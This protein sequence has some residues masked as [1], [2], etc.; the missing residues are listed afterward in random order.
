[1]PVIRNISLRSH[2]NDLGGKIWNPAFRWTT[3]YSVF[4][5]LTDGKGRIGTGECWCFDS[6]PEALLAFIKT[7]VA[8]HFI[9]LDL[10]QA[11]DVCAKLTAKATLTARHGILAS[12]LSGIDIAIWDIRAQ[13]VGLPI[14]KCL[15]QQGSG[16]VDLYASG[17]LYGQEKDEAA[18]AA[19]MAGF[20]ADG[21]S[22]SKMKIGGESFEH[23]VKRVCAVIDALPAKAKLIVDGVYSYTSDQALKIYDALPQGRI[24]AFQ[25]P[26]RASDIAGM[27]R[28]SRA[29]VPVMATEAE[30]RDEMHRQLIDEAEIA[31]LQTAPIACGGISRVRAMSDLAKGTNTRLSLEV[32]STAIAM[33]A[34]CHIAAADE[35]IAHVEY[36]SIHTVFFEQLPFEF[37]VSTT[38]ANEMPATSG[39][40][41]TLDH[42]RTQSEC[43]IT[44][45]S[46]EKVPRQ[47]AE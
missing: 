38:G 12:A 37:P 41:I 15:N 13:S 44:T 17:G 18:L 9:D 21:F 40:G 33:M 32:S 4:L 45:S 5:E 8:P 25:S 19:E 29:S 28:L 1:M 6:S 10:E 3:T 42:A 27:K 43:L 46:L 30:Y 26:V 14:W 22:L 31:F 34:A 11:Q 2:C 36:H 47:V 20:A 24:A 23:D 16:V 39:L 35:M 7:E